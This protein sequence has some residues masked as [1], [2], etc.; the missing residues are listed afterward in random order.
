MVIG[1]SQFT[2]PGTSY[3]P[4]WSHAQ[5]GPMQQVHSTS[6]FQGM[7]ICRIYVAGNFGKF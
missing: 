2:H 4:P 1:G 7:F 5:P 6:S 3:Q